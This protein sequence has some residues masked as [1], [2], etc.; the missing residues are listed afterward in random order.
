MFASNAKKELYLEEH[1]IT[2]IAWQEEG[3]LVAWASL[4]GVNVYDMRVGRRVTYF[5]IDTA[6]AASHDGADVAEAAEAAEPE[7]E[8][9]R[10]HC[11][12][13]WKDSSVL[14]VACSRFVKVPTPFFCI[15]LFVLNSYYSLC[16]PFVY[17][18]CILILFAIRHS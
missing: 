17:S 5:A 9:E 12:L 4:E 15:S 6:S 11:S 13:L 2:A 7:F 8:P 18:Y 16:S 1:P 3:E 14:L 10:A